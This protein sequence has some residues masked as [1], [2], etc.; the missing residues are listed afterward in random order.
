MATDPSQP[1][2][3]VAQPDGTFLPISILKGIPMRAD[4][5]NNTKIEL[6]LNVKTNALAMTA[7]ATGRFKR[8]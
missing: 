7:S 3:Q 8:G 2:D 6:Q 5:A 4:D 1:Y